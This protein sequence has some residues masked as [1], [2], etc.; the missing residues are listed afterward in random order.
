M[1]DAD[2][3]NEFLRASFAQMR[4]RPA[5]GLVVDLRRNGGVPNTSG[6]VYS[7]DLPHSRLS[8][9]ISSATF[10]RANGD[11]TDTLPV[12]PTHPCAQTSADTSVTRDTVLESGRA[13]LLADPKP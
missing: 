8:L 1:S 13:W 5:R 2:A 6:E 7:C 10:A 4:A 3:R 9:G 11:G 12:Q